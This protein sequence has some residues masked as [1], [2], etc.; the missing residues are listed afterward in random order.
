MNTSPYLADNATLVG[1]QAL[2]GAANV[3]TLAADADS[4]AATELSSLAIWQPHGRPDRRAACMTIAT[5][6][7]ADV[8]RAGQAAGPQLGEGCRPCGPRHRGACRWLIR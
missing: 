1:F 6:A 2:R 3:Y 7:I 5:P 8:D 4:A